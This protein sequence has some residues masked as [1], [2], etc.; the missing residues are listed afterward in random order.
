[1]VYSRAFQNFDI[2]LV[3]LV[4]YTL[5]LKTSRNMD[6]PR[7]SRSK[8]GPNLR[9]NIIEIIH[10]HAPFKLVHFYMKNILWSEMPHCM[11]SLLW[12]LIFFCDNFYTNRVTCHFIIYKEGLITILFH[13]F[14]L[15]EL[16]YWVCQYYYTSLAYCVPM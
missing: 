3:H 11:L 4:Y 14:F 9:Y 15:K 16:Q 8:L 7:P 12:Y 13:F 6:D 1:M 5:Q 10:W 2:T